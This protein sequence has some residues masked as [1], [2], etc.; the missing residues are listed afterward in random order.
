VEEP[1]HV[2]LTKDELTALKNTLEKNDT[3]LEYL[4]TK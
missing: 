1:E 3:I 2:T 4:N